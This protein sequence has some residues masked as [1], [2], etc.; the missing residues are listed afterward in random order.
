MKWLVEKRIKPKGL[1]PDSAAM[2]RGS[3][4]HEVLERTLARIG[5][6]SGSKRVSAGGIGRAREILHEEI[7]R[8]TTEMTLAA[9][10]A[11]RDAE[12]RRLRFDLVRMLE[13]EAQAETAFEPEHLELGFGLGE[14]PPLTLGRDDVQIVGKI[15]RVDTSDGRGI[16]RDYK[17]GATVPPAAKWVEERQL[18]AAIYMLAVDE[19]L[20]L[21]P[22]GGVYAPLAS[23]DPEPRGLLSEEHAGDI[24]N[25]YHEKD[26]RSTDDFKAILDWAREQAASVIE[27]IRTGR[28]NPQPETCS[29][30]RDGGCRYPTICRVEG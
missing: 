4:A 21:E 9:D 1:E 13:R 5:E 23:K 24:G 11:G 14:C 30:A 17:S 18:Q 6:E 19:V 25:G 15:D 28:F 20:G 26:L 16:V 27:D 22:V 7:D 8:C 12:L 3:F 2:L 29:R 10:D